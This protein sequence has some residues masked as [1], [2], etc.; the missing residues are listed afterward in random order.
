MLTR[1][2]RGWTK[3]EDADAYK[4]FL[5]TTKCFFR[6]PNFLLRFL[7]ASPGNNS[8]FPDFG[9]PI[10]PGRKSPGRHGFLNGGQ[11]GR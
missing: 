2:W 9:V 3:A 5:K 11:H 8:C 10:L 4:Q 1:H 6:R 7:P